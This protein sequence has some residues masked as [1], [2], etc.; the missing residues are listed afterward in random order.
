MNDQAPQPGPDWREQ[1]RE[2]RRHRREIRWGD[3]GAWIGGVVL[4][5]L[6]VIFL[7]QNLGAPLPQN[8]W[9][10]FILIP[11]IAS[12][13]SAWRTYQR[14]D[15]QVTGA[16][17]GGIVGGCILT[18]LAAALFFGFDWGK[19]WP[20]ILILLGITALAGGAWRR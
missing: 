16:V 17:R 5:A 15:R 10:V 20:V 1:R 4:I 9:A 14:N 6:G 8:W 19:Y 18:V 7:A 12:F 3:N 2:E 11:A 13:G